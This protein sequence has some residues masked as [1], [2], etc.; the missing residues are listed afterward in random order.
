VKADDLIADHHGIPIPENYPEDAVGPWWV[1]NGYNAQLIVWNTDLVAEDEAPS[2]YEELLD[3]Q[4]RGRV[5]VDAFPEDMILAL[6]T[7]WGAERA[8]EWLTELLVE[9]EALL[10]Q[11]ST[12]RANLLAAGEFSVASDILITTF[13]RLVEEEGA[14]L[15]W[16]APD[17]TPVNTTMPLISATAPSPYAALL[18]ISWLLSADGGAAVDAGEGRIPINPDVELRYPYLQDFITPG[19]EINDRLLVQS[20]GNLTQEVVDEANRIIEEV[21]VPRT[22]G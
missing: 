18:W 20:P 7:D 2:S 5:A 4:W 19:S 8:E 6:V 3:P 1:V 16:A 10:R 14:P 21:V 13:I 11:G 12:N 9:N 15:D 17:P 22:G